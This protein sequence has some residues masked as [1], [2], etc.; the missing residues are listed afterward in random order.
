VNFAE[1]L[2]GPSALLDLVNIMQVRLDLRNATGT[3]NLLSK[4]TQPKRAR[5]IV[6]ND[7]S[8]YRIINVDDFGSDSRS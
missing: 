6:F 7:L 8:F 5:Y 3:Q 2:L 1:H 4:F